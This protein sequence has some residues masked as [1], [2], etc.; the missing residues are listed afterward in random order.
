MMVFE[1]ITNIH[2]SRKSIAHVSAT[3]RAF[4]LAFG[5]LLVAILY[6][7]IIGI[8]VIQ[9]RFWMIV[10][11]Q[12]VLLTIAFV[13]RMRALAG[14]ALSK[15]LPIMQ[16]QLV[17]LLVTNPLMTNDSVK[18]MG[19]VGVLLTAVG[20]YSSQFTKDHDSATDLLTPFKEIWK[21]GMREML[22]VTIIFSVTSNLDKLAIQSSSG[23]FYLVVIYSFIAVLLMGMMR[24]NVASSSATFRTAMSESLAPKMLAGG[25]AQGVTLIGQVIALTLAPVP[26]VIAFKQLSVGVG[27]LWGLFA[28]KD[29]R[30]PWYGFI[31][32]LLTVIGAVIIALNR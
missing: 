17:F 5:S 3:Q 26:F 6:L 9:P 4:A 10:S 29:R 23:S 27:S 16:L 21:P 14:A 18:F 8:P 12:A 28:R 22:F 31:G 7:A 1:T 11:I 20:I 2:F 30:I 19:W 13:L 32:V 25:F 15:V 24:F